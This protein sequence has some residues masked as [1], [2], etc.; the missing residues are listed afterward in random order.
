MQR[1]IIII[2]SAITHIFCYADYSDRG[3]PSD[4]QD[5]H[6]GPLTYIYLG[7]GSLIVLAFIGFWIYDKISKHNEQISDALGTIFAGLLI[8]GGMLLV[9]K[10]GE[11]LHNSINSNDNNSEHINSNVNTDSRTLP[12]PTN[13]QPSYQPP[14]PKY[15]PTIRYRTVEY[16]ENC[17]NCGGSGHVLCPRCKGTGQYR[18]TCSW[19]NGSGGYSRSRCIY[20][21][22]NGYTEDNVF[23][24]GKQYC[25]NCNGTG[26]V[27]NS[28]QKCSGTGYESET[29]DIYAAFGQETHMVLCSTCNG[30]GRI[31]KTRQESYYE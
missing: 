25:I 29:C 31:R 7:I 15:T 28:C 9:G 26:Y 12:S 21:N 6:D 24:S 1:V 17:F 13:N 8:F 11:S 16:Y 20:C 2:L 22:G 14:M 18:R 19:C 27:E 30:T 4:Y 3:R 10:C 23:G 5:Y